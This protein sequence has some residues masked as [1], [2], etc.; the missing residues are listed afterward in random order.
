M[1]ATNATFEIRVSG[2]GLT[3]A[4]KRFLE[5]SIAANVEPAVKRELRKQL[6]E[7]NREGGE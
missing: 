5:A 7:L 6:A 2:T 3:L 1:S 4:V